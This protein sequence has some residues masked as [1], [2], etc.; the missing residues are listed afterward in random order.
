MELSRDEYV[1][2]GYRLT[3][4]TSSPG[5]LDLQ[6]IAEAL[7]QKAVDAAM[8]FEGWDAQQ[9]LCLQQRAKACLEFRDKLFATVA[10]QIAASRQQEFAIRSEEHTAKPEEAKAD[11]ADDLRARALK[12][13]EMMNVPESD[14]RIPG[15]F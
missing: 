5:Y 9:L 1:N 15:A 2:R 4:L 10:E 7:C 14:G 12:L 11:E 6:R 13:Y 8:R 3:S